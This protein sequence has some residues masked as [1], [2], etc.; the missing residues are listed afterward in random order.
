MTY[1]FELILVIR[2]GILWFIY[3]GLLI[4]YTKFTHLAQKLKKNLDYMGHVGQ[5]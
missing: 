4:F 3:I 2:L 5:D 1:K